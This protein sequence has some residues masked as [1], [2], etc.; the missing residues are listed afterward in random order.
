MGLDPTANGAPASPILLARGL[1]KSFGATQVLH[2]VDLELTA[3]RCLALLGPNGAGKTTTLEL[4]QGLQSP[5]G[6]DI[7]VFGYTY[8]TRAGA[9]AIRERMNGVLQETNFYRKYSVEETV[10]LFASFY[11]HSASVQDL[12]TALELGDHRH[13]SIEVLSGGL[14]Q[15]TALACALVNDPELLF[16]DE[17]TAGLDPQTRRWLWG[18]LLRLK[19]ERGVAILLTTH[20]MHEAAT[21]ADDVSLLEKGRIVRRGTPASLVSDLAAPQRLVFSL[22]REQRLPDELASALGAAPGTAAGGASWEITSK[23]ASRDLAELVR[24]C[25]RAGLQLEEVHLERPTLEDVFLTLRP[26]AAARGSGESQGK[27]GG[28]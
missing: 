8:A 18:F 28:S 12:L 3:G 6:G 13:K 17:P 23:H 16:L 4:L 19:R 7:R 15:R 11:R 21:L 20:D 1:F 10:S 9:R 2:G 5:T 26:G 24:G 27:G 22:A 25:D 14:R